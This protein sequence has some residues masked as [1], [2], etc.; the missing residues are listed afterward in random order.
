MSKLT[1]LRQLA[2]DW[3]GLWEENTPGTKVKAAVELVDDLAPEQVVVLTAYK[4]TARRIAEL[5]G[6][7]AYTGD[8]SAEERESMLRRFRA[9]E[10]TV[11]VGTLATVGE[12]VDGLQVARHVVLVDRDWTPARNEQAIA[13]IRRSGQQ[14]DQVV[15]Y[16]IFA[17]D[18]VD[19]T[20]ARMLVEKQGVIDALLGPER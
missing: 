6:A 3:G 1:R 8:T 13:R 2:S 4:E 17:R 18:T 14:A 10:E 20:V 15:A 11:L 16:H 19:E 9:G 5:V 12:G 7:P